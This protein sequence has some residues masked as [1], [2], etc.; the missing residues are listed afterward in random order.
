VG[1]SA[2]VLDT[3]PVDLDTAASIEAA[4]ICSWR[5]LYAAAPANWAAESGLSAET[6]GGAL[7][8]RWAATGRRYFSRVIGLGLSEPATRRAIAEIIAGYERAGISM[9]L[10]QSLPQCRPVRYERWLHDLGFE[11]FDAQDRVVRDGRPLDGSPPADGERKLV[12]EPVTDDTAAAWTAF[13]ERHYRLDTGP[14]LARLIGRPGWHQYLALERGEIVAARGMHVGPDGTAWL[15]M[16][17]PVPG[18]MSDDYG[19]DAAL[20]TRIV[21]DGLA[22]GARRFIADIE[23]PSATSAARAREIFGGLGFARPYVRT[24]WA[25]R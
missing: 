4:E 5:D 8:L 20:C 22:Y 15:G 25:R 16:D 24:H 9:Y 1:V 2:I 18:I 13:L 17:A 23:A 6:L 12:V 11:P 3:S 14:W 7:I 21:A 10:L 19:P